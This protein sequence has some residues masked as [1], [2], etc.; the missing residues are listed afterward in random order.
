MGIVV[1]VRSVGGIYLGVLWEDLW[2]WNRMNG[3]GSGGRGIAKSYFF[4]LLETGS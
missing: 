4:Q 3:L 1:A 2:A